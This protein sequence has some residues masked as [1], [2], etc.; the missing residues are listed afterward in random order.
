LARV[1][2]L[3]EYMKS[4]PHRTIGVCTG[5]VRSVSSKPVFR[6]LPMFWVMNPP[7]FTEGGSRTGISASI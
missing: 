5:A 4:K 7:P 1:L 6:M 3:L 2:L